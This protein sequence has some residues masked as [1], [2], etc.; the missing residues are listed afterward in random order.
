MNKDEDEMFKQLLNDNSDI[1]QKMNDDQVKKLQFI[2]ELKN[3][4]L[5]NE[6]KKI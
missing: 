6:Q 2:E 4:M 1:L 5:D 3:Q